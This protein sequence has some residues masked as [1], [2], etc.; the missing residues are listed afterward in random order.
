MSTVSPTIYLARHATPDWSRTDIPYH[1]PPGP[2]LT[3]QGE[4][5]A[6]EL[7]AYL[8]S[9]G[10]KQIYVSPLERCQRTAHIAGQI[11]H[12]PVQ[13]TQTLAEWRPEEKEPEVR[14]RLQPIW[15]TA[16]S[17]SVTLGPITLCTHGGPIAFL[18]AELGLEPNVLAHYRT[19]F[20]RRNPL[21]PAGVWRAVRDESSKWQLQLVFTPQA[22]RTKW[23]I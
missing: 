19:L 9:A 11:A 23:L 16:H 22:Y 3:A 1:L 10:V 20:D 5:E 17:L 4:S 15:E 21:P 13:E 18:L 12:A 8:H 2:P 14:T 7:G 6:A